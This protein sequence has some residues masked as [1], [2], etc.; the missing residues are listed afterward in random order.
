MYYNGNTNSN[1]IRSSHSNNTTG[2]RLP[3]PK[4]LITSLTNFRDKLEMFEIG[5]TAITNLISLLQKYN[6]VIK[7]NNME[8]IQPIINKL[9]PIFT[10]SNGRYLNIYHKIGGLSNLNTYM[11]IRKIETKYYLDSEEIDKESI[12]A[13]LP[14]FDGNNNIKNTNLDNLDNVGKFK[15]PIVEELYIEMYKQGN[16]LENIRRNLE[17]ENYNKNVINAFITKLSIMHRNTASI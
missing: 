13:L 1:S 3:F 11:K 8:Q 10:S 5:K 4:K 2:K 14:T 12:T 7:K 16:R 6:E 15:K 17:K 9:T